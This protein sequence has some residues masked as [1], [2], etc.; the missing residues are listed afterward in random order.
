MSVHTLSPDLVPPRV[1]FE[2]SDLIDENRHLRITCLSDICSSNYVWFKDNRR[3]LP[4][5]ETIELP[6]VTRK[7]AGF[8]SCMINTPLG[9]SRRV[10]PSKLTVKC[11]FELQILQFVFLFS[12]L[13]QIDSCCYNVKNLNKPLIHSN[14]NELDRDTALARV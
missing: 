11:K 5:K 2:P 9:I 4:S 6:F 3:L 7:E 14:N 12:V 1:R 13:L 8:Y 10:K